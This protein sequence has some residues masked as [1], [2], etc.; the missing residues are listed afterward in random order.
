MKAVLYC[1]VSTKE[2]EQEG[3]SLDAQEKTGCD[4]A[5]RNNL[6]IDRVW[7][8]SES[9]WSK[10]R[11]QFGQMIEYVKRHSDIDHVIFDCLDRM[12]R[13]DFDK[14]KVYELIKEHGKTIHFARTGKTINVNSGSD[15]EFLFDIEVAVAKKWSNDISRKA[16]M[17]M[18][19]K[20]EQGFYPGLVPLGYLNDRATG[21]VTVDA[22][23]A[24]LVVKAFELM[25]SGQWSLSMLV[26]KLH[27]L[28]LRTRKQ[29]KLQ[30]SSLEQMLKNPFY[31]GVFLW[32]G[33]QY[34]G[35][36][37]PIITK[38][39]FDAGNAAMAGRGHPAKPRKNGFS[40]NN[41]ATCGICDCKVIGERQKGQ[42]VYYHCTHSK[43]THK[44]IPYI[45]EE[46]FAG[47][48]GDT[49]KRVTISDDCLSWLRDVLEDSRD[50]VLH[51]IDGR[52]ATLTREKGL[53]EIRLSR[54][55]DS[56]CDGVIQAEI[57]N[58]K[59]R[60]YKGLLADVL[61]GLDE[62]K[63]DRH[64]EASDGIQILEQANHLYAS[65]LDMDY[66]K[67]AELLRMIASNYVLDRGSLSATYRKPFKMF[68]GLPPCP[69]K[70]PRLDL[71][72]RPAD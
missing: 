59:E 30:K 20:A 50:S 68:L 54:L 21:S 60:E 16:S 18:R 70:L 17:G 12:T 23:T 40:F 44:G 46:K 45:R 15:D 26:D 48:L 57:F 8:M 27:V 39:V 10:G 69:V 52:V 53:L 61:I 42:Y 31:Y 51:S 56:L 58:R 3:F 24:P 72:Q 64:I 38:Q 7:K 35:K 37:D 1:R 63:S 33:L 67:K 65:Y 49:V 32:K 13:N 36:H 2:Q 28:G 9:A 55:C 22:E 66:G 11:N 29:N 41:L 14:L 34:S 5:R 47:L 43:G 19:E 62:C 71:N 25:A 6:R 4:Y